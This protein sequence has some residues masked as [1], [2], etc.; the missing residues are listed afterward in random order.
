M[1]LTDK[2]KIADDTQLDA[3]ASERIAAFIPQAVGKLKEWI[4]SEKYDELKGQTDP[5]PGSQADRARRCE[6]YLSVFYAFHFLNLRPS[7]M[8]GFTKT[9]GWDER[10]EQLMSLSELNAYRDQ[11]YVQAF[12]LISD[13]VG[14]V[15]DD[16]TFNGGGFHLSIVNHQKP[17]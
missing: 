14:S 1:P 17:Q 8:G 6:S 16:D 2:N 12:E 9:I 3:Q 13:M 4:G 15:D 10:Q 7:N 5:D 11:I